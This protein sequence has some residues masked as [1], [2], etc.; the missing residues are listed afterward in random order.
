MSQNSYLREFCAQVSQ[1]VFL[2]DLTNLRL[3]NCMSKNVTKLISPRVLCTSMFLA[4]LTVLRLITTVWEKNVTKLISPRVLCTSLPN[5]VR[6]F[7]FYFFL[8][9]YEGKCHKTHICASSVHK[10]HK[11]C[12]L[13]IWPIYGLIQLYEQKCHQTHISASTV[14]KCHKTCS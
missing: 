6:W 10:C 13:L 12:S 1:I 3:N 5:R 8:Q 4:D 2:A 14:H 9:L 11:S 7:E